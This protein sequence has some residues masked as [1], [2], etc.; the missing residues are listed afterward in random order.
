MAHHPSLQLYHMGLTAES[1]CRDNGGTGGKRE[2]EHS[3]KLCSNGSC[4]RKHAPG[5]RCGV[6][7]VL[8]SEASSPSAPRCWQERLWS[9]V[10]RPARMCSAA[11]RVSATQGGDSPRR[12]GHP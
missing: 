11:E 8:Q 1:D 7:K 2:K 3:V 5:T 12:E 10:M 9:A 6:E 4:G